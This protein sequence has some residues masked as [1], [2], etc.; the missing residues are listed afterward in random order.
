M[1]VIKDEAELFSRITMI[2]DDEEEEEEEE[3]D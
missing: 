2:G 3:E 1:I